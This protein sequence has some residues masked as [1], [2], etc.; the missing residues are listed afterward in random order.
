VLEA[1][2]AAYLSKALIEADR[3]R[4]AGD[5]S[6]AASRG[7]ATKAASA[8]GA[9]AAQVEAENRV[10]R[11]RLNGKAVREVGT[12]QLYNDLGLALLH[13]GSPDRALGAFAR[14]RDLAP[15]DI[16]AYLH[17]AE[18][19]AALGQPR[20]ALSGLLEAAVVAPGRDDIRAAAYGVYRQLEPDGCAF[21]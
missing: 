20:D 17:L 7:W 3:E 1:Q 5:A 19:S 21:A 12:Q 13:A 11:A 14:A 6:R 18:T 9:A 16:E 2:G 4:A 15:L 10:R 8:L